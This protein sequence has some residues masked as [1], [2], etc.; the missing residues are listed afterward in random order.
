[1][2]IFAVFLQSYATIVLSNKRSMYVA[3]LDSVKKFF[4]VKFV[5]SLIYQ[6][7]L[8]STMHYECKRNRE[9]LHMSCAPAEGD[10]YTSMFIPRTKSTQS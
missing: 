3:H 1:M 7:I 4:K 5:R 9:S 10:D 6:E 2:L 8:V